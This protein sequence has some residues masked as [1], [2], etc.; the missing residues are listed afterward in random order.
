MSRSTMNPPHEN[1]FEELERAKIRKPRKIKGE[2]AVRSNA[3]LDDY[4]QDTEKKVMNLLNTDGANQAKSVPTRRAEERAENRVASMSDVNLRRLKLLSP[5]RAIPIGIG[6]SCFVLSQQAGFVIRNSGY[7]LDPFVREGVSLAIG[8]V[9]VVVSG[10][11]IMKLCAHL[12]CLRLL[13]VG[14]F[15]SKPSYVRLRNSAEQSFKDDLKA[16]V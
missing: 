4:L 6:L 14:G 12:V 16:T 2:S 7:T 8:A 10:S 5:Q 11:R 15:T 13:V 1:L 3:A 9:A